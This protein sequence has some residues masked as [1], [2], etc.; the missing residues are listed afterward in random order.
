MS[1]SAVVT[2]IK[3]QC[4]YNLSSS[5]LKRV[6]RDDEDV[7]IDMCEQFHLSKSEAKKLAQQIGKNIIL[8]SAIIVKECDVYRQ[9]NALANCPML[10]ETWQGDSYGEPGMK[11]LNLLLDELKKTYEILNDDD[12]FIEKCKAELDME[13]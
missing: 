4:I 11:G 7:I 2:D 12:L 1:L 13:A 9:D 6:T 8:E 3:N 10:L 5:I